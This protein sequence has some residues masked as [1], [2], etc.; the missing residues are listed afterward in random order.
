MGAQ[1]EGQ[2]PAQ[3]P[4]AGQALFGPPAPAGTPDGGE[5][6]LDPAASGL[7]TAEDM[8]PAAPPQPQPMPL[9]EA[10]PP[11]HTAPAAGFN[12]ELAGLI[13]EA[14]HR[15]PS[16]ASQR[17]ALRAAG[18]DVTAAWLT[19]LPTMSIQF[20]QYGAI[21]LSRQ[22]TANVDLPLWSNGKIPATI[23]RAR[24]S[25]QAQF[26]RLAE[27]VLDLELEVNQYYHESKRLAEHE[28][29]LLRILAVMDDMVASMRRRVAQEVSPLADLQLA[30]SRR[31]QVAQQLDLVRAQKAS[32]QAHLAELVLREEVPLAPGFVAPPSWPQWQ[33]PALTERMITASPQRRRVQ[34]EAQVARDDAR[35]TAASRLPGLFASYSYD[36]VYKHRVGLSV[37][38]Q[39]AGGF[40]EIFSTRAARLRE[41]A[42]DLQAPAVEQ[43]MK[44]T[45]SNDL[46]EYDS[47]RA[48]DAGARELADDSR[49][50]TESYVRQFVGGRRTWLDV[51]NAVREAMS[52]DLDAIDV[53]YTAAAAAMRI[54]LRSGDTKTI[55]EGRPK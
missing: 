6:G 38:M 51:M 5:D 40:S 41:R 42:S 43:D 52:A 44:A 50:I 26:Y 33:L 24:A 12:P 8:Q 46:V 53:R 55:V 30:S 22:V 31:L 1:T 45:A 54:L 25:R 10:A 19:R 14:V 34:A 7:P 27:T 17:A 18:V 39:T 16:I 13:E 37:R 47:A 11:L 49:K 35:I 15:H 4:A 20:N 21:A 2:A 48:R 36:E 3:A 32:A 28:Q 23:D 29:V 9:P